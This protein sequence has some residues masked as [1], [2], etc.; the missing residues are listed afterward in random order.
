MAE[1]QVI[2]E[3]IDKSKATIDAWVSQMEN[4]AKR[5]S[6]AGA[7]PQQKSGAMRAIDA[8]MDM[9]DAERKII[10]LREKEISALQGPSF[11]DKVKN[12]VKL[13]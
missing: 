3:A 6:A 1:I 5:A 12:F 13:F 8:R 4:A 2:I 11:L 7:S 9:I 10:D